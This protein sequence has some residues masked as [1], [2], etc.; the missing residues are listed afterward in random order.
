M[1]RAL[2]MVL[3]VIIAVASFV[4]YDVLNSTTRSSFSTGTEPLS[5]L[6]SSSNFAY[7][8][9]CESQHIDVYE[10]EIM[11]PSGSSTLTRFTTSASTSNVTSFVTTTNVSESSGYATTNTIT[12]SFTTELIVTMW[13]QDA[14]TYK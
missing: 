8:V 10:V 1:V 6:H 2:F 5:S 4:A 3:V 7:I 13:N 12:L 14:C 9:Y 11:S